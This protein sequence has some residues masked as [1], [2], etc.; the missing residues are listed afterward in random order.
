MAINSLNIYI[1]LISSYKRA[2]KKANKT[3]VNPTILSQFFI[4]IANG[5]VTPPIKTL[6]HTVCMMALQKFKTDPHKYRPL[7]NPSAIRRIMD[8][9]ILH[10]YQASFANHLLP[11]NYAFVISGG[12]DFVA[13]T[14]QL[15]VDK[16]VYQ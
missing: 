16:E 4:I 12:T 9:A 15:S 11:F 2:K 6:I 14:V 5:N 10:I 3:F 8:V 13:S 7:G 1:K